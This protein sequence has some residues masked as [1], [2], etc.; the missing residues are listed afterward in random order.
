MP[1]LRRFPVNYLTAFIALY[2]MANIGPGE[3]VL[4]HGG[5]GG[6]GIAAAQLARL[7]R[8]LIIATASAH[9]HDALRG[10][11]VHHVIDHQTQNVEREVRRI[12]GGR[13]VDVILDPIGG[14]SFAMSYRLLAPLG[15]LVMYGV[16]SI[17]T[18]ERRRPWHVMRTLFQMPRFKPISMMNHNRGVF[19]L[20]LAHLWTE[21]AQLASATDTLL[22][23]FENQRSASGGGTYLS[24]SNRRPTLTSSCRVAR[25][26]ERSS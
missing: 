11:G 1:R 23:E 26:S 9:K 14:A 13:G 10:F 24:R 21:A 20:N 3:T 19:G 8:A 18:G 25:T 22:K 5:G 15:R 4:V 6:V 7:R 16:S 12:T 17:A 2:R